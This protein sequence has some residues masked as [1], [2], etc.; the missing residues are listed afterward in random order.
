MGVTILEQVKVSALLVEVETVN[1]VIVP[2]KCNLI[3]GFLSWYL[4]LLLQI[5]QAEVILPN[6]STSGAKVGKS[7]IN[8]TVVNHGRGAADHHIGDAQLTLLRR[9]IHHDLIAEQAN[10]GVALDIDGLYSRSSG[11][12]A[13]RRQTRKSP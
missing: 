9:T 2:T 1:A 4:V 3:K 11:L 10:L 13:T 7:L 8:R 5:K 6:S 12:V